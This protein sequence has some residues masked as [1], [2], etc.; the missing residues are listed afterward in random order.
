MIKTELAKLGFRV[1]NELL[2]SPL[3]DLFNKAGGKKHRYP[4]RS[5]KTPNIQRHDKTLFNK[6]YLCQSLVEIMKIPGITRN[7]K[8]VK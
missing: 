6:S 3:L 7:V 2:P 1:T 8:T 5:K 4:M